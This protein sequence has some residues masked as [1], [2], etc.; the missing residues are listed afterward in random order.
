M[1]RKTRQIG[2][3]T[4]KIAN[5]ELI[6]LDPEPEQLV[7]KEDLRDDGLPLC[8]DDDVL[9]LYADTLNVMSGALAIDTFELDHQKKIK[10]TYR[11]SALRYPSKY[12]IVAKRTLDTLDA[13]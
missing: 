4:Q 9:Q 12:L 10:D 3:L 1:L 6:P 8:T 7:T 13:V 11:F 2:S 5:M